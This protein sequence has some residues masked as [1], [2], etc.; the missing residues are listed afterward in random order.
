MLQLIRVTQQPDHVEAI[1]GTNVT[2]HCMFPDAQSN[3]RIKV[4][5]W[6]LE[7]NGNL[8]VQPDKRKLFGFDS[9]QKS[10]FQLLNVSVQDSG[11]YQCVLSLQGQIAGSGRGSH[12]VVLGKYGF[13]GERKYSKLDILMSS[14][15]YFCRGSTHLTRRN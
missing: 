7:D 5:W 13:S 15:I 8:Q 2:F 6:K 3:S 11:V 14:Q 12:L 4:Y 10:F 9:D 1:R